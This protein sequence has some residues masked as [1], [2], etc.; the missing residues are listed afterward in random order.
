MVA[1]LA[2]GADAAAGVTSEAGG[3]RQG[4]PGHELLRRWPVERAEVGERRVAGESGNGSGGGG[5]AVSETALG[6]QRP[7]RDDHVR[8]GLE[9]RTQRQE[10]HGSK[11]DL[12]VD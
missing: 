1:G 4:F 10:V 5:A 6:R 11:V 8:L 9:V 7:A 12:P 2:T 3:D